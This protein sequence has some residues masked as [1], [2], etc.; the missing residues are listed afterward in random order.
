MPIRGSDEPGGRLDPRPLETRQLICRTL[1]TRA[2]MSPPD[3][4]RLALQ[5][6]QRRV[7]RLLVR[8]DQRP[9]HPLVADR[10]QDTDTLRRRERQVERCRS[11]PGTSRRELHARAWVPAIHHR[12][13][14]LRIELA[15]ETELT[16]RAAHPPARRLT[17]TGVVVVRATRDF[18]LVVELLV[19]GHSDLADRQHAR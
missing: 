6:G 8:L 4:A 12:L 9:R 1:T 13:Q 19:P 3:P 11:R 14:L 15:L 16:R 7:D 10:K 17:P 2:V 5:I 18:L